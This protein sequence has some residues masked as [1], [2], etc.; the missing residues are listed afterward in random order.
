[1]VDFK[2]SLSKDNL[3]LL[4]KE[5][6]LFIAHTYFSVPMEYHQGKMF[7]NPRQIDEEV[8]HNFNYLSQ[9][10]KENSVWNPTLSELVEYLSKFEATI[11][12]VD[13]DGRIFQ[14]NNFEMNYRNVY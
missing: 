7:K 14:K 6:G 8:H 12:D 3:D 10:I 4:V 1:M 11:F 9:K 2:K 13:I 5:S